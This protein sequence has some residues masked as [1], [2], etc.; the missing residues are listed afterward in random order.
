MDIPFGE[1]LIYE[2]KG[3]INDAKIGKLQVKGN[4]QIASGDP[5]ALMQSICGLE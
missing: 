3:K 1:S 5:Y 2:I 4:Y